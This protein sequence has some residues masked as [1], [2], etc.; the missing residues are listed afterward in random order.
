M[1]TAEYGRRKLPAEHPRNKARYICGDMNTSIIKT[2]LGRTIVVK[3]SF[4]APRPYSMINLIQG[5]R[6]LFAG[7]PDR[8]FVNFDGESRH[9]K[10]DTD[11]TEWYAKYEHPLWRKAYPIGEQA[12]KESGFTDG[13][14]H[15]G[16]D[17]A[18]RW[19]IVQCLRNGLPL[20]QDVYDG[21]TWSAVG[22][23]S[24]QSVARNGAS[25]E[26]PDFTRG[27]WKTMKPL[28]IVS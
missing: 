19:R 15:G 8:I 26:V 2:A 17:F 1:I 16:A 3:F 5:A 14:G 9:H 22:P 7:Y 4:N 21:V 18:M 27:A 25:V 11:L 24:E 23:V 20:D 28:G 13:M 10:W 12:E 6:G